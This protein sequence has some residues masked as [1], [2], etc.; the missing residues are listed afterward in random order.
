MP[1]QIVQ[2]N[3]RTG[4]MRVG[5]GTN[6]SPY[7]G[8]DGQPV[9]HNEPGN[10]F[11]GFMQSAGKTA[12][13]TGKGVV[14]GI[15]RSPFD[16]INSILHPVDTIKN[17][18]SA[19]AHPIDTFKA[20]GDPNTGGRA[21]GG[22]LAGK[23]APSVLPKVAQA[24]KAVAGPAMR[25]GESLPVVGRTVKA[26]NRE[27]PNMMDGLR[28]VAGGT[29]SPAPT[30]PRPMHAGPGA[31]S[32]PVAAPSTPA[33][34]RNTF[35]QMSAEGKFAGDRTN[36]N[37]GGL[38]HEAPGGLSDVAAGKVKPDYPF[39]SEVSAGQADV[40]G[41]T[42]GKMSGPLDPSQVPMSRA[43][44]AAEALQRL[45]QKPDLSNPA[46]QKFASAPEANV[47]QIPRADDMWG[48]G[49]TTKTGELSMAGPMKGDPDYLPT[50]SANPV[51]DPQTPT[52][53]L[54]EQL[55]IATDPAER[56]FLAKALAQRSSIDRA[57]AAAEAMQRLQ[58]PR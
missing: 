31:S 17:A 35:Q 19:I 36:R 1:D 16:L 10:Y 53:Y 20:L 39:I 56:A 52:P 26:V 23:M 29:D 45:Q 37:I 9:Q 40:P 12:M 11:E 14:E 15:A 30:P 55:A 7:K 28:K 57:K 25:I 27:L 4:E 34:P 47:R 5:D 24:G 3:K 38:E 42:V 48:P 49:S 43:K 18:A 6:W 22:I 58:G 33:A 32:R 13:D 51:Y 54:R 8:T 50:K 46:F 2:R 41:L 21:I 44:Q